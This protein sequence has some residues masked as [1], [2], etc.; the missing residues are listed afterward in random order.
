MEIEKYLE[1]IKKKN[2]F[3]I[4]V[5]KLKSE[6]DEDEDFYYFY[7]RIF[8]KRREGVPETDEYLS[9]NEID[10]V[11]FI[12][13]PTYGEGRNR[14]TKNRSKNFELKVWTYGFY[15]V[16]AKLITKAGFTFNLDGNVV[17]EVTDDELKTNEDE[18]KW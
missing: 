5:E 1:I 12:L 14:L 4:A 17:F 9:L 18:V 3:E 6:K 8:L 15:K 16:S 2:P 13:D 10:S 7:I 11:L